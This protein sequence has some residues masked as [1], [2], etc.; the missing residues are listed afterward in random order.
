[1]NVY[2]VVLEEPYAALFCGVLVFATKEAALHYIEMHFEHAD[3]YVIMKRS[4][5]D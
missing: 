4:V 3:C 2:V 5:Q 1:M